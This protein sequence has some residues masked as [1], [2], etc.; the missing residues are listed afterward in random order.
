MGRTNKT[1]HAGVKGEFA[2]KTGP[3]EWEKA[4]RTGPDRRRKTDR[5]RK[6]SSR[7][8]CEQEN[9]HICK[10]VLIRLLRLHL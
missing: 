4:S 8:G 5:M 2:G 1:P 10:Y 6:V 3:F 7:T 9:E